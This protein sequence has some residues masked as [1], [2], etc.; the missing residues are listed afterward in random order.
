MAVYGSLKCVFMCDSWQSHR[1][2]GMT[3][4]V[5]TL[6][7]SHYKKCNFLQ[8]EDGMILQCFPFIVPLW[9]NPPVTVPFPSHMASNTYFGDVF[10]VGLNTLRPRQ[11]GRRFADDTFK[12][13]FL[14][15]NVRISIKISLKFVPKVS[16]NNFPALVQIMAWCRLGDKPLSEPMM[17]GLLRHICVTRPQ[18][19]NKKTICQWF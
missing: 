6:L 14:N 3:L 19:V 17:V 10:D 8:H 2:H 11:N 1:C 9:G 7:W 16:I 4:N 15:E 12:R 5:N 18:S 13:I